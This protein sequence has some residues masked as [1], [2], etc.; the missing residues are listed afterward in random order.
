MAVGLL[1]A[2]CGGEVVETGQG[3]LQAPET[4]PASPRSENGQ[5]EAAPRQVRPCDEA[6]VAAIDEVIDGQLAAFRAG[7]FERALSFASAG[8]R[9]RV[10]P[11]RFEQLITQGFPAVRE[12]KGHRSAQCLTDGQQA[13]VL[14]VVTGREGSDALA[15]QMVREDGRWRINGAQPAQG[16]GESEP[17]SE[18]TV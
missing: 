18:P 5:S 12:A 10:P 17:G 3:Q 16:G 1:L 7:D 4:T 2:A 9:A 15:Y 11:E 13:A 14:V 8:F 6:T